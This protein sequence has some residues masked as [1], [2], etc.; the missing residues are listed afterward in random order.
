MIA[1][2]LLVTLALVLGL[3][4]TPLLERATWPS[5][6]PSLGLL[7]WTAVTTSVVL[8][9]I[10]AGLALALPELPTSDGVAAFFHACSSALREHYATPG[11][12]ILAVGGG[13]VALALVARL[14]FVHAVASRGRRRV[15][16]RHRD[17]VRLVGRPF[18]PGVMVVDCATPAAYCVPGRR[19]CVVISE[20]TLETLTHSELEQ[21]LSHEVAHL[22]Y[23]H[24]RLISLAE[25][26]AT[27]LFGLLGTATARDRIVELA[28]MHADD[29]V[30]QPRRLELA[31][32]VLKLAEAGLS[33]AGVLN[34][35]GGST[36]ARVQRLTSST[37]AAPMS[38]PR[39][40]GML[41]LC[42]VTLMLPLTLA[43]LPAIDAISQHYCP[44]VA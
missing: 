14:L 34:V 43:V 44:L 41:A 35:A 8:S 26:L 10:F 5:S 22:A 23:R 6:A 33:P 13:L 31:S 28:E 40:I 4:V 36:V 29:S 15:R 7:A 3:V 32:A 37:T 21:V 1:P 38:R 11:G 30:D 25:T 19:G 17:L 12:A 27:A 39:A 20:G 18:R 2:L 24:H 9:L 16:G 42:S